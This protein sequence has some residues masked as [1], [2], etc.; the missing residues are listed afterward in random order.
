MLACASLWAT[1]LIFL[2]DAFGRVEKPCVQKK[3]QV[4]MEADKLRIF[5]AHSCK[6]TIVNSGFLLQH[7]LTQLAERLAVERWTDGLV[8]YRKPQSNA[9]SQ[10]VFHPFNPGYSFCL[11]DPLLAIAARLN[12]S[13]K[14]ES[15][16]L[17][18]LPFKDFKSEFNYT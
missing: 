18:N 16:R 1:A 7:P 9:T 4:E 11:I 17:S 14:I 6:N 12:Q 8:K 10:G 15:K 5:S 13:T 2:F 3:R